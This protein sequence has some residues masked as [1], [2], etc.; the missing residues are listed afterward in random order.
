MLATSNHVGISI[1]T[2]LGYSP[3]MY[4]EKYS[5]SSNSSRF[6]MLP[7]LSCAPSIQTLL[8]DLLNLIRQ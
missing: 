5:L 6:T 8:V 4:R 1:P 2:P 7:A 3:L